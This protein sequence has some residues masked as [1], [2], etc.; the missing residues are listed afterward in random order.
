MKSAK[1]K[2]D[3]KFIIGKIESSVSLIIEMICSSV[4]WFTKAGLKM[5][6]SGGFWF[7]NQSL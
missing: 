3:F 2:E 6:C 7:E 5:V 1:E 4:V